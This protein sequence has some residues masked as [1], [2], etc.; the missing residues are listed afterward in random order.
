[1]N[2]HGNMSVYS[3]NLTNFSNTSDCLPPMTSWEVALFYV[4]TVTV[5]WACVSNLL[6]LVTF[7]R[8]QLLRSPSHKLLAQL[9]L[10]DLITTLFTMPAHMT[11]LWIRAYVFG[12]VVCQIQGYITQ[13]MAGQT[14]NIIACISIDRFLAICRPLRY[15]CLMTPT[16]VR[17]MIL[18]AW[19]HTALMNLPPF[20]GWG[21]ISLSLEIY[22]CIMQWGPGLLV[23]S[24]SYFLVLSWFVPLSLVISVCSLQVYSVA[25][26]VFTSTAPA[27][28]RPASATGQQQDFTTRV[29][30]ELSAAVMFLAVLVNVAVS[31]LPYI[32]SLTCL[33]HMDTYPALRDTARASMF[34]YHLGSCGNPVIYCLFSR[35]FRKEFR[36]TF[37]CKLGSESWIYSEVLLI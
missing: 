25:R 6:V 18:A 15:P 11:T 9:A 34:L 24:F 23:Q 32:V 5:P 17:L 31:R 12:D 20:F 10:G 27:G 8:S 3:D 4:Y 13:S 28:A 35:D 21:K 1:M 29:R 22:M 30:S 19:L 16:R 36:R 33:G 26:R 37:R 14:F 7:F 2:S